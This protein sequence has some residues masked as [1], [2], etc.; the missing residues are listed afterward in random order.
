MCVAVA[1]HCR[2]LQAVTLR[3]G[4]VRRDI[5][6]MLSPQTIL[7]GHALH[8]D[9]AALH[10]DHQPVIDTALLFSYASMPNVTPSLKV[11]N[12]DACCAV[13]SSLPGWLLEQKC[14]LS[15]SPKPSCT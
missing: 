12:A 9:L 7:V 2:W 8:H 3:R 4:D 15:R 11:G 6:A 1:C 14:D 13:V 10:L 5:A